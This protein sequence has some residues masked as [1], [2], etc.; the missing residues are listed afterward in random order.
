MIEATSFP[1]T[2]SLTNAVV[3]LLR[4]HMTHAGDD[5]PHAVMLSGGSTPMAAYQ[6]IA[7]S[8]F[9]VSPDLRVL[10]SDDRMALPD[11]PKSNYGNTLPMLKALGIPDGHVIRVHAEHPAP[12]AA[13]R[14]GHE[15]GKFLDARG[16]VTLGLLG[17]GTDGHTAS[18]FSADHLR[19]G[20]GAWAIAVK[21]PDGLDG[22]SATPQFIERVERIVFLIAGKDKREMAQRLLKDS[23]SIP[24]GKAVAGNKSVEI[25]TDP[26]ACP[27]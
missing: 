9:P 24:A 18:L 26:A 8:P 2:K 15:L 7:A 27:L 22:V 16:R 13:T 25:W 14:Y 4:E 10:F 1:D 20:E 11:S 23:R 12:E 6:A 3:S 19:Q 5:T 21:R 17:L